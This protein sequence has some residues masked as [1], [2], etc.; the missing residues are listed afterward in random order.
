VS[1]RDHG[2]GIA[3]EDVER[4][5]A[6]FVRLEPSRNQET[7]GFGLGLTIAQAIIEGH[8]GN[9][10]LANHVE[11]GLVVSVSLSKLQHPA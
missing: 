7:G 11:G 4:A 1:I 6:P 8:G 5:L 9:M 3:P 10:M 2:P